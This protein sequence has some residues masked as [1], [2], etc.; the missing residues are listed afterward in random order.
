[1]E[2]E[3]KQSEQSKDAQ[4]AELFEAARIQKAMVFEL[5]DELIAGIDSAEHSSNT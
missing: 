1:M 2:N 3:I 5:D 4:A